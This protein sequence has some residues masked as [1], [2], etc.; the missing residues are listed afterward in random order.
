V[1]VLKGDQGAEFGVVSDI[2]DQLARSQTLRFNL[3]TDLKEDKKG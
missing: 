3:M 2:M 1:V